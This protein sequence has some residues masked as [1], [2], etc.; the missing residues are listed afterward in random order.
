[1]GNFKGPSGLTEVSTGGFPA[2][3]IKGIQTQINQN[4]P[5]HF[6]DHYTIPAQNKS[7][8]GSIPV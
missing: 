8:K 5:D 7:K 6:P 3:E 4:L 1:M 2:D